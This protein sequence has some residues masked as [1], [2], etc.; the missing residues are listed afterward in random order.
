METTKSVKIG[1]NELMD[2]LKKTITFSANRFGPDLNTK[3]VRMRILPNQLEVEAT[4]NMS[5]ILLYT[6]IDYSEEK[7]EFLLPAILL[8]DSIRNIPD[9]QV[10]IVPGENEIEINAGLYKTTISAFEDNMAEIKKTIT[11]HTTEIKCAELSDTFEKVA[12]SADVDNFNNLSCVRFETDSNGITVVACDGIQLAKYYLEKGFTKAKEIKASIP[13]MSVKSLTSCLKGLE[14]PVKI[15]FDQEEE[16]EKIAFEWENG[17]VF[18]V[19]LVNNYPDWRS[20][21]PVEFGTIISFC[22]D[23]QRAVR[24]AKALTTK[25]HPELMMEIDKDHTIIV[26]DSEI[27]ISRN[28]LT[29]QFSGSELKI[30]F[31]SRRLSIDPLAGEVKLSLNKKDTPAMFSNADPNWSLIMMPLAVAVQ[32]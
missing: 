8:L 20:L 27:G 15:G 3:A 13:I 10:E 31:D 18:S 25:D 30:F 6:K 16:P 22:E 9:S 7:K 28:E 17:Y 32:K 23:F 1:K 12:F 26:A 4:N 24:T 21:I 14:T 19:L 5:A 29:P 11:C 2:I